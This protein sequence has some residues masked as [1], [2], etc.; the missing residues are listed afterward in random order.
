MSTGLLALT[1]GPGKK[2]QEILEESISPISEALKSRSDSSKVASVDIHILLILCLFN[3]INLMICYI[4]A[5]LFGCDHFCWW[6]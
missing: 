2:A 4:V 6:K 1:T 3:N 5:R